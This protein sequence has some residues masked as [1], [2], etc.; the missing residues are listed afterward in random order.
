M[1]TRKRSVE[2]E[3][4]VDDADARRNLQ[5]IEQNTAKTGKAFSSMG[6]LVKAGLATF[7]AREALDAISFMDRLNTQMAANEQRADTVFGSMADSV[8]QWADE[9]NEAFGVGE[10]ALLGLASNMQDLLVPMGFQRDEATALTKETL[11]VANALDDWKGG[12]LGVENA[13]ER[14]IKAMLGERE[15]LIELNLKISEADVKTRLLEKGQQDLTGAA[16]EQAKAQATLELIMGKSTDALAAYE[17]RAGSAVAVQKEL[18]AGTEDSA[19]TWARIFK[20]AI[21]KAKGTL[22]DLTFLASGATS[23][24]EDMSQAQRAAADE[25]F[26]WAD[27]LNIGIIGA[28]ETG[29]TKL[30]EFTDELRGNAEATT[31]ASQATEEG[32]R[33][34]E[35]ADQKI[36]DMAAAYAQATGDV[37][38]LEAALKSLDGTEVKVPNIGRFGFTGGSASDIHGNRISGI[39]HEGG[40][41]PGPEGSE[42]LILAEGGETVRTPEQ[43][44][45]LSGGSVSDMARIIQEALRQDGP[46]ITNNNTYHLVGSTSLLEQQ[47][48]ARRG[49]R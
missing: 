5:K 33:N 27:L 47:E 22:G 38:A 28:L 39:F 15:G 41:V 8:R 31:A 24:I 18:T 37:S 26:Q 32:I 12:T 3:V 2:I 9:Q 42:Q 16:L 1:P 30:G 36:L 21:D 6:T 23:G 40:V 49:L 46:Q 34:A 4:L 43:E 17:E 10:N 44:A 29:A 45:A 20:P 19:E 48:R 35:S 14:I 25:G 11:L 7:G 13:T